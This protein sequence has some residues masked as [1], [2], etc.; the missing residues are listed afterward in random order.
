MPVFISHIY[1]TQDTYQLKVKHVFF[2]HNFKIKWMKGPTVSCCSWQ[3]WL[4]MMD[5]Q[6]DPQSSLWAV[7]PPASMKINNVRQ[8]WVP[9][10][11]KSNP[12]N[13]TGPIWH[14]STLSV[15]PTFFGLPRQ[16]T[17]RISL[18]TQF[19]K[20]RTGWIKAAAGTDNSNCSKEQYRARGKLRGV[21]SRNDPGRWLRRW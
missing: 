14:V 15:W 6:Y 8:S 9:V 19:A 2:V 13:P 1:Q 4:I 11:T 16:S 17:G 7:E 10:L 21:P 5:P 12:Q 20:D 3:H 18:P